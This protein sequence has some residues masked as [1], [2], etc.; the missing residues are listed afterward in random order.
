LPTLL[1]Q[2]QGEGTRDHYFVRREGGVMYG[3][4]T[5]EAFI[6]GDWKILQ[7]SPFAPIEMYNLK[8]DPQES[9]DLAGKNRPKFMELSA[10]LRREV[11]RGGQV[12][13]QKAP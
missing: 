12:P 1:G 3:G 10:E 13:W 8:Q 9:N 6:R 5:I 7:D 4:K 11:Q 2:P